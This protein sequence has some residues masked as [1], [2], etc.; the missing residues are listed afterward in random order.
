MMIDL[1]LCIIEKVIGF[2]LDLNDN[3]LHL[4]S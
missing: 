1:L 4:H 2:E 3:P